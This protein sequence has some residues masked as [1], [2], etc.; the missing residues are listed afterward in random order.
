MEILGDDPR[1]ELFITKLLLVEVVDEQQYLDYIDL[2]IVR[3]ERANLSAHLRLQ[4]LKQDSQQVL[5]FACVAR[6]LGHNLTRQN[7]GALA[8]PVLHI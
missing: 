7:D 1:K 4:Q 2:D 8:Q 6:K 5:V 3:L